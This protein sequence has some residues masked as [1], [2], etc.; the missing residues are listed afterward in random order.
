VGGK[1]TERKG[2]VTN[3]TT[4]E[5][6]VYRE[7]QRNA[8]MGMKAID[9]LADVVRDDALSFQ[10]SRQS[11]KYGELFQEAAKR[12]VAEKEESYR[13]NVM[14]DAM[15]R[16]G[17]RYNTILNTSTSHLAELMIRGTTNGIVEM[18][19]TL[20]HNEGAGARAVELAKQLISVEEKNMQRLMQY[21]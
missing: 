1:S 20:R 18:E 21:L 19:K 13:S 10:M 8:E 7:I 11:V 14:S 9:A 2:I 15:L 6:T 4:Q 16:A 5:A 12:L 3:M 17:I